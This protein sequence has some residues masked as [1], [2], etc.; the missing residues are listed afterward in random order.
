MVQEKFIRSSG[1][2]GMTC[3]LQALMIS[4]NHFISV[5]VKFPLRLIVFWRKNPPVLPEGHSVS[6]SW[7][8]QS[9]VGKAGCIHLGYIHF[10]I[11]PDFRMVPYSQLC[12]VSSSLGCICCI[13]SR[14]YISRFLPKWGCVVAWL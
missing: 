3:C 13:L 5:S 14:E 1:L 12:L 8:S 4:L 9:S 6:W 10:L 11:I 7:H 2:M